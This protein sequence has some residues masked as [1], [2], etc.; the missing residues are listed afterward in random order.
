MQY[1]ITIVASTALFAIIGL[2]AAWGIVAHSES[3]HDRAE[4]AFTI[5]PLGGAAVGAI[6]GCLGVRVG[7][8]LSKG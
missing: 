6:V 5:L 1:T 8:R 3:Y 7:E 4:M 2:F